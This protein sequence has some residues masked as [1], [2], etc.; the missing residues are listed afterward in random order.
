MKDTNKKWAFIFVAANLVLFLLFFAWPALLGVYYSLTEYNGNVATFIG[1]ENYINLFQDPSFYKAMSRTFLYTL[2]GVPLVYITSLFVSVMLTSNHTKGKNI[3]KIIFFFP[4]LV[5]PIV[6]GVLWRW[7]FGESFG[8]VNFVIQAIGGNPIPWSSNGDFAFIVVLFATAWAGTAFNMLI[9]IGAIIS[10]PRSLYEAAD[11][12]G[13]SGWQKFWHVTLPSIRSTSF[14]VILLAVFNLMK[15]FPMVQS[16][17]NGGPGTDTTFIVQYIYETGFDQMRVGYA[18]AASM[19]L[20]VILLV[21]SL[22][23]FRFAKGGKANE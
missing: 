18:S 6:V 3:A 10:I 11:V 14:L 23:Q 1:L 4:W 13:G 19:V 5:S 8:F 7:M 21:F 22:L 16:L 20:F 2:I 9:F 17:T 12:D 15:E